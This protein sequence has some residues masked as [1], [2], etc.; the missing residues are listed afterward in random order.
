MNIK[1]F[2]T[3]S[4]FVSIF[5]IQGTSLM[6]FQRLALDA[7]PV[8]ASFSN[9][10]LNEQDNIP[11]DKVFQTKFSYSYNDGWEE[12]AHLLPVASQIKKRHKNSGNR[13][14]RPS[15]FTRGPMS[16]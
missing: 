12:S 3:R 6:A 16:F 15:L 10:F 13:P 7:S 5:A 4:A 9:S 11:L 1:H 14:R 8:A 2:I